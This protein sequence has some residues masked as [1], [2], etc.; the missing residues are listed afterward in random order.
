M[1][2]KPLAS[3]VMTV[4][5]GEAYIKQAIHS[6]QQQTMPDI[7]ICV[8]MDGCRDRTAEIVHGLAA[9]DHRIQPSVQ[10]RIGRAAALNIGVS[11]S[12]GPLVAIMDADDVSLPWRIERS[13]QASRDFGDRFAMIGSQAASFAAEP[14][15]VAKPSGSVQVVDAVGMLRR[16]SPFAHSSLV[17]TRGSF[18]R[19]GG[20]D[21]QRS[22]QF[23]YDLYVRHLEAGYAVGLLQEQTVAIRSH[24]ESHFIATGGMGYRWRANAVQARAIAATDGP[25]KDRLVLAARRL[26]TPLPPGARRALRP[27]SP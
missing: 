27:S 3:V 2:S 4:H 1:T 11:A 17:F 7:E 9:Q 14:P 15:D 22:G 23:D 10:P 5:D 6:L 18:E 19:L 21:V 12:A 13:V 26:A 24:E 25:A 16:G 20:Y 8:V